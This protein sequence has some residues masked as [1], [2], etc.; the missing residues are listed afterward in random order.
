MRMIVDLVF[1]SA[2]SIV[3]P[4]AVAIFRSLRV[5]KEHYPFL[6]LLVCGL[7]AEVMNL[8]AKEAG[9]GN[10][11]IYNSYCLAE[12]MLLLWLMYNWEALRGKFLFFSL[13]ILFVTGWWIDNFLISKPVN[14]NSY[15]IVGY[16]LVI[17]VLS[18][19]M[20]AKVIFSESYN[21]WQ[22]PKFLVGTGLLLYFSYSCFYEV[23]WIAHIN[24]MPEFKLRLYDL[25][26]YLNIVVN[27][28]F[29]LALL[30]LPSK[31]RYM[32]ELR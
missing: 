32:L 16:S 26:N 28:I 6:I 1:I 25:L 18:A 13:M 27:L 7:V 20:I 17:S 14:V 31:P 12:G 9:D 21:L 10:Q 5:E 3:P 24:Y 29:T 4:A 8:S 23:L 11:I 2:I 19:N 22:N 15:Y 30:C